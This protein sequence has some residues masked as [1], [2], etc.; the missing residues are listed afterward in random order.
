[1]V[2]VNNL[3]YSYGKDKVIRF[4]DFEVGQ[5]EHTLLLGE[6]GCG[7]TTLLHLIGGLLRMQQGK[8]IVNSIALASLQETALDRFR[9]EN[10]GFIFQRNH[11]I[12]ALSVKENLMMP[13]FLANQKTSLSAIQSVMTDLGMRDYISSDVSAL[14]QG[15]S[16]RVVI[17]R[18]LMNKPKLILADE[19]T[20]ALDDINCERVISLLIS[21]AQK[22]NATLIIA[23]HDQR[24]KSIVSRQVKLNS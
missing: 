7:K 18:A 11:L 21:A 19:P 6:S 5:E 4:P 20:S 12:G 17:A 1:M 8:I 15:Q 22:N 2:Q 9:G 13:A 3:A 24:L 10:I 14:S 23:T 16:Q